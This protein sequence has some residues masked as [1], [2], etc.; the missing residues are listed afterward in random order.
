MSII[1]QYQKQLSKKESKFIRLLDKGSKIIKT[2]M[3]H[4]ENMMKHLFQITL[5]PVKGAGVDWGQNWQR[6]TVF[7]HLKFGCPNQLK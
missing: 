2:S 4:M 1:M 6:Y 7:G 3:T 5:V